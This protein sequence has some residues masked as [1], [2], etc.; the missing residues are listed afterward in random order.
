M[1]RLLTLLLAALL[2]L[3]GCTTADDDAASDS[4]E[5]TDVALT[6]EN[7]EDDTD[8]AGEDSPQDG[9]AEFPRTVHVPAGTEMDAE[10]VQVPAQPERIAAL[11]YETAVLVA[12]LGAADRL[13][14]VP[15]PASNEVLSNHSADLDAV[16]HQAPT[17]SG[18]SAEAVI[19]A[20]PDLVLLNDR[21]GLEEGVGS[22]LGEAGIPV[23]VLPNTWSSVSEMT[24]NIDL[25]GT[26]LGLDQAAAELTETIEAGLVDASDSG[27][28]DDRPRVL[29]LSNQAGRPFVTA[30]GAFPL[31]LLELAGAQDASEALG[32]VRS[33]PISAEQVLAAEPDRILLVDMTGSGD[34]V[35]AE[36]LNNQAVAG[37]PAVADHEVLLLEGKD[38]QALG[39]SNT[40]AGREQ[41]AEWLAQ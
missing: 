1:Y 28:Q 38:V 41:I 6:E 11:T 37:L 2:A 27:G 25:V 3:A 31:E 14:M 40:I 10:D 30:G 35:F 36:L 4:T 23:L 22:V 33:G 17:E 15:G 24:T 34:A 18:V 8:A 20:D 29:V 19:A 16:E 7:A 21:H 39:L 32:M 9:P 5:P 26:A 13:T 12:E